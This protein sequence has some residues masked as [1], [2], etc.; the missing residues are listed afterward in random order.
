MSNSQQKNITVT[1][2]VVPRERFSVSQISLESIY[3]NTEMPFE[4]V[5][6]DGGSPPYVQNYLQAKAEEKGFHLQR[7]DHFLSPNQSRN[8]GL[9]HAHG[10]YVVFIDND[11]L[12]TPGW[13]EKM[14]GCAEETG[15]SV[16][17]PLY[18]IGKPE[19]RIIHMAGGDLIVEETKNGINMSEQH[20]LINQPLSKVKECIKREKCDFAEFHCMLVR[21]QVLEDMGPFD[22]ELYSLPEHI[23]FCYSVA[24]SGGSTWLEPAAQ[25]SYLAN[26]P[27]RISDIPYF[28]RRWSDDWNNQSISHFEK[29]WNLVPECLMFGESFHSWLKKHQQKLKLPG[30]KIN[31]A[32][33]SN[34]V[35]DIAQTNIQLYHQCLTLG[36]DDRQLTLLMH[37]YRMAQAWF[38][39]IYRGCGRPFLAHLVGT[40]SILAR[41]GASETLVA[42]GMLHSVY[43]FG[44]L[45]N[46]GKGVTEKKR[47][48][49][50]SK[51]SQ[52]IEYLLCQYASM[53]WYRINPSA[54]EKD[55]DSMS[56]RIAQVM[57]MRMADGLEERH[58]QSLA[59]FAKKNFSNNSLEPWLPL[60]GNLAE[61][62]GVTGLYEE[63]NDAIHKTN[64][65]NVPD[66]IFS[67]KKGSYQLTKP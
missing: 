45:D 8:L 61:R 34:E 10:C 37:T 38:N 13:L 26:E 44:H 47:H 17:A 23:D 5:Y 24:L 30:N 3:Q 25:V 43:E 54:M 49:V 16:V 65:F 42:A 41:Y 53:N 64:E 27:F 40:A 6:V 39:G 28:T 21:K 62:L 67:Q 59:F 66:T 36:Y 15:A 4:L 57:L 48:Y 46:M 51:T 14:I 7:T 11:V 20:R 50:T 22:E 58:D 60:F 63:L 55:L 35:T 1:I 31:G 2:I 12:V 9:Q 52:E 56:L 32:S 33:I 19:D 29:K 18:F